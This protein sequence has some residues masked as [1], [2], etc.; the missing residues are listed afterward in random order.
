MLKENSKDEPGPNPPCFY[1]AG[2]YGNG[3]A[4]GQINRVVGGNPSQYNK[5]P[6]A[7][8]DRWNAYGSKRIIRNDG[9]VHDIGAWQAD[10]IRVDTSNLAQALANGCHI[11][12]V[13]LGDWNN[14]IHN[15][16]VD[17]NAY[18]SIYLY[19]GPGG[20]VY[21]GYNRFSPLGP[22]DLARDAP[23]KSE[24]NIGGI[25]ECSAGTHQAML[26]GYAHTK[27][28]VDAVEI[29]QVAPT[30]VAPRNAHQIALQPAPVYSMVF[31][32]IT[33][34][35]MSFIAERNMFAAAPWL[36]YNWR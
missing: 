29:R 9:N 35:I 31:E 21:Q 36:I 25:E 16:V 2:A 34:L 3:G 1:G 33:T 27:Q 6:V 30:L 24:M 18:W 5:D 11:I 32:G 20:F 23:T 19:W 8:N 28:Q 26:L 17:P 12:G 4:A 13:G 7:L 15:Q 10:R 22:A 14:H